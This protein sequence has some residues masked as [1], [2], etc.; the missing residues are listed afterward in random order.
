MHE[1]KRSEGGE[2]FKISPENQSVPFFPFCA[3]SCLFVATLLVAF[4]AFPLRSSR[5]G[6]STVF[7]SWPSRD[8][9]YNRPR[10]VKVNDR[11]GARTESSSAE[12]R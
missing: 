5:L 3:F 7:V 12:P 10:R 4:F 9:P 2:N 6:G 11:P 8:R 1:E